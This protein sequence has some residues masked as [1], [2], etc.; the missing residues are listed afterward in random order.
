MNK[1]L[2]PARELAAIV[3]E[4][5]AALVFFARSRGYEEPEDAVQGALLKLVDY[6]Y[7]KGVPENPLAWLYRAIRN[8]AI[9]EYRKRMRRKKRENTACRS[10]AWFE[11]PNTGVLESAE[12]TVM[13][14]E[15]PEKLREIVVLRIWSQLSFEE[16]AEV[17]AM[18]KT[19]VFRTYAEALEQLR[20]RLEK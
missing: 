12:A 14:R 9:G 6:S 1:R 16:I 18:S 13:L 8:E 2:I 4:R 3:D 11:F 5:F 7:K 20:K 15:L 10:G 17:T 19:S